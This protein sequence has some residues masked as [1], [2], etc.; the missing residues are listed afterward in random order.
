MSDQLKSLGLSNIARGAAPELFERELQQVMENIDDVNTK[1]DATRKITLEIA[2]TPDAYREQMNV[3]VEAKSKLAPVR[4]VSGQAYIGRK[5]GKLQAY[6][7]DVNQMEL[8]VDD[9]PQVVRE[10]FADG[11]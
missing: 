8:N 11:Q 1:A 6:T 5:N 2:I 9:K 3:S 7:H 4:H 10:E